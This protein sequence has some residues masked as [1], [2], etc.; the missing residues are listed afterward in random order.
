MFALA[1]RLRAAGVLG[2]N[3]RNADGQPMVMSGTS[4][5][6]TGSKHAD[7]ALRVT[8]ELLKERTAA[9][10]TTL[11]AMSQGLMVVGVDLSAPDKPA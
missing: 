9:L 4:I 3:Q 2:I 5:D 6:I 1:S 10:E 11:H 8:S 7:D